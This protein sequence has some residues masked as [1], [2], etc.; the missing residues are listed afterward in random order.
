MCS[1]G[2]K[3][4]IASWVLKKDTQ[5]KDVTNQKIILYSVAFHQIFILSASKISLNDYIYCNWFISSILNKFTHDII[6]FYSISAVKLTSLVKL[7]VFLLSTL[8][9][10]GE[11][12]RI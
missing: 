1:L 10:E 7:L 4:I 8:P 11:K 5:I 2:I 9:L 6:V 3:P 12:K